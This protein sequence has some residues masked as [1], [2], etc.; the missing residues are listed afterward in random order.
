[1]AVR[2]TKA[3]GGWVVQRLSAGAAT[4][5]SGK[6]YVCPGCHR[7]VLRGTAHVVAWPAVPGIGSTSALDDRRHWHTFCWERRN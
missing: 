1:M 3:D 2:E 6:V 7:G 4:G 5:A